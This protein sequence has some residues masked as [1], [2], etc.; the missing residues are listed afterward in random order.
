MISTTGSEAIENKFAPPKMVEHFFWYG[1]PS[2]DA[3]KKYLLALSARVSLCISLSQSEGH[4]LSSLRGLGLPTWM[5][6]SESSDVSS[7]DESSSLPILEI[8]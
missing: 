5:V 7:L 4:L 6:E 8:T 2:W 3:L 1:R